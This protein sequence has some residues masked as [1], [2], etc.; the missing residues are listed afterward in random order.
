MTEEMPQ[1]VGYRLRP[2][3]P[4]RG[5]RTGRALVGM[6]LAL[7]LA[8]AGGAAGAVGAMSITGGTTAVTVANGVAAHTTI[9]EIA[10]NVQPSVVSI[11]ANSPGA[12]ATGSG[13]VLRADGM[14]VTNDH[15]VADATGITV[16]FSDGKT[17]PARVVGTSADNDLAVIKAS[18]VGQVVPATLGDSRNLAAGDTV[19]A[20]GSPLGLDGSVTAGIVSALNRA[21]QETGG[22]VIQ[23][24][25]QTDAAINPGNSGGA[26]ADGTGAIVGINT[27]IAT[28]GTEA[29]SIGVGFA[30]PAELV[31]TVTDQ[32]IT[33]SAS[34][35]D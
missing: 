19:V 16:K 14:I 10:A 35:T 26:L 29:G 13:V 1:H 12:Q 27:A 31:R 24:A 3:R 18:R 34:V 17:S 30:I 5:P 2:V 8:L 20:I 6:G 21:V 15:V 9:S 23:N 28:T 7:S 32:I 33:S 11:T 22:A 25:I 4:R